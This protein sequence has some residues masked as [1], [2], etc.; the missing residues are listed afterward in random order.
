[1]DFRTHTSPYLA[2]VYLIA[3]LG[4]LW[5]TPSHTAHAK[6]HEGAQTKRSLDL[7]LDRLHHCYGM[8]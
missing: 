8:D 1:M 3:T 7:S 2:P 4:A 5:I 6:R